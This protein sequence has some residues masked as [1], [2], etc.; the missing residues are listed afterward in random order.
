[1]PVTLDE[2]EKY[3]RYV[4]DIAIE[5]GVFD[6]QGD[7]I[8][9][10]Y[11]DGNGFLGIIQT[12]TLFATQVASLN[13]SKE[14]K[15]ATDLFK[16]ALNEIIVERKDD[17]EAVAFLNPVLEA[18]KEEPDSPTHGTSKF[19]VTSF[20]AD[21]DDLTQWDRYG[22]RN[23]YA[24]G[25]H[26]RGLWREPNSQIYRVVYDRERQ[27]KA[28]KKVAAAT[29]D[30]FREGLTDERKLDPE[31]WGR[32]FFAA[33]D[34]WIYKLAPLAKDATWK[35]E[36]EFRLVHELKLSEFSKIRF[37]QKETMLG[38]FL[39]LDTPNWVKRRQPLLPIAK[40]LIGHGNH[41]SFTSVS[42]RLLLEQLGYQDIPVQITKCSLVR[43]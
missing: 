7:Q 17:V 31:K 10:H 13:D 24:I 19:F 9:W 11:T 1:M 30:F 23:A 38:R 40:I 15:Y 34:E 21:E 14:T 25:F 3:R 4:N 26:A 39:P 2:N 29:L 20:S 42:V 22:K 5:L 32:E 37:S 35:A 6:F 36:N 18:V 33:W 27:L 12:G 41:P 43:V 28:V 8:V 16:T